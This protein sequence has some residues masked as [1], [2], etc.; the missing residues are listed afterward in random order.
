MTWAVSTV[1]G[2]MLKI[3]PDITHAN[4]PPSAARVRAASAAPSA[5]RPQR[6]PR[7]AGGPERRSFQATA[8]SSAPPRMPCTTNRGAVAGDPARSESRPVAS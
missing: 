1:H 6:R 7:I 8:T 5:S 3:R 4:P 2:P